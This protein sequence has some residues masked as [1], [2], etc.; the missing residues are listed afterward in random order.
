MTRR[1]ELDRRVGSGVSL[2]ELEEDYMQRSASSLADALFVLAAALR[3]MQARAWRLPLLV[4][5]GAFWTVHTQRGV[6]HPAADQ[7]RH[8]RPI[9]S[10]RK[11]GAVRCRLLRAGVRFAA[12]AA[13]ASLVT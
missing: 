10:P 12:G 3:S 4:E 2:L 13:A 9:E 1:L 7:V 5:L 6:A 8:L 11:H